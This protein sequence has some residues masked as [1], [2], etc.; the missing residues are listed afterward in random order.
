MET[1]SGMDFSSS[2]KHSI[3]G[4]ARPLSNPRTVGSGRANSLQP[5]HSNFGTSVTEGQ[6]D[7][8]NKKMPAN[9]IAGYPNF[10]K[11]D[12][13]E[14]RRWGGNIEVNL[15][16]ALARYEDV[17]K[18]KQVEKETDAKNYYVREV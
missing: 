10:L 15:N 11:P 13:E 4:S 6:F 18:K 17:L 3:L 12:H 2:A 16:K 1:L 14:E 7:S 9:F 8:S 5:L